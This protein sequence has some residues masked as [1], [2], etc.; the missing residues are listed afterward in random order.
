MKS[1]EVKQAVKDSLTDEDQANE[2]ILA[3]QA[4]SQNDITVGG[5]TMKEREK[6][7]VGGELLLLLV[8]WL[9]FT[10]HSS[11]RFAGSAIGSAF[12]IARVRHSHARVF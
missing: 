4:K 5:L 11:P 3:C 10:I 1:G 7:V 2:I 12:G 8:G 6:I 9:G